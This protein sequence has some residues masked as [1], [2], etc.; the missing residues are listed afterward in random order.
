MRATGGAFEGRFLVLN[1][2]D[3][4]GQ[5]VQT[6]MFDPDREAD[7]LARFDELTAEPPRP[8]RRVRPN[9]A[10][11]NV[12]RMH[13]AIL[14]RNADAISALLAERVETLDHPTGAVYDRQGALYSVSSLL[15][16]PDLT[17]RYEPL[18]TLGPSLGL[19][20]H[21]I[22]SRGM[23]RGDF[24]VGAYEMEKIS[25]MEVDAQGR[26]RR[27]EAFASDRLDDAVAR[28]YERYA[29]LLPAGP[30]RERAAAIARSL[31]VVLGPMDPDRFA[32]TL[33][34][35]AELWDH[36]AL[37]GIG[38]AGG[39]EAISQTIRIVTQSVE[40][41]SRRIDEVID[42]SPDA[43]LIRATTGGTDRASGGASSGRP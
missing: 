38:P 15:S 32:E 17:F 21:S 3:G 7:A 2:F 10:T 31:P 8:A 42:A 26:S 43:L 23:A 6:E 1:V 27:F 19:F 13:D 33:S 22:E 5:L 16:V 14:A 11:S 12:D 29:E 20:R 25:V 41:I 39:R 24:D 18:A 9:A 30:A 4:N 28:L 35:D 40:D 36:R 34:P 37:V